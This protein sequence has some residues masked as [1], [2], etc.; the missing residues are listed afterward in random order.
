MIFSVPLVVNVFL[1]STHMLRINLNHD[2]YL[3]FS[4]VTVT[5]IR[6]IVV[7]TSPLAEFTFQDMLSLMRNFFHLLQLPPQNQ[8]LPPT[9]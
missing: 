9:Y 1:I 4:L 7:Y 6:G 5:N 2:P 3:V 8:I